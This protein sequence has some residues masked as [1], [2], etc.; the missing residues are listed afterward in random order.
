[1]NKS[2]LL[3]LTIEDMWLRVFSPLPKLLPSVTTFFI[4]KTLYSI[5]FS[6][7]NKKWKGLC[8]Q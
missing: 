4:H 6:L 1:M 5:E 7:I 3:R 8:F 2:S